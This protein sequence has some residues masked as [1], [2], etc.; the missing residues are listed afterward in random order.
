MKNELLYKKILASIVFLIIIG[1]LLSIHWFWISGILIIIWLSFI[2]TSKEQ[3]EKIE[4]E[5]NSKKKIPKADYKMTID[6]DKIALKAIYDNEPIGM[7]NMTKSEFYKKN[8]FYELSDYHFLLGVC[9]QG[10]YNEFKHHKNEIENKQTLF[11][12]PISKKTFD[13]FNNH[14]ID[15]EKAC[16]IAK[17]YDEMKITDIRVKETVGEYFDRKISKNKT[18]MKIFV[19]INKFDYEKYYK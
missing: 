13:L 10:R 19:K 3:F 11:N 9:F 18:Y 6:L 4:L 8:H 1:Y 14:K 12:K 17:K 16:L 15:L 5:N 2:F 7:Y